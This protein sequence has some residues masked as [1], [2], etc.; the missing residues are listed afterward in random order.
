MQ[1]RSKGFDS[2]HLHYI[3]VMKSYREWLEKAKDALL[4]EQEDHIP[5]TI[6]GKTGLRVGRLGWG[7]GAFHFPTKSISQSDVDLMANTLLDAG[8]NLLD[9]AADYPNDAEGK[10]GRAIKGKRDQF[11]ILTK[12]G[13]RA[14]LLKGKEWSAA[15][16]KQ[17]VNRSLKRLQTDYLD[18]VVLHSADLEVLKKGEAFGAL[19]K[20]KDEGKIRFLGYSGDNEE[21]D[22]MI[23]LPDTSVIET[24]LNIVELANVPFFDE[25]KDK[26]IGLLAKRSIANASWKSRGRQHP[27]NWGYSSEYRERLKQIGITPTRMGLDS[28]EDRDWVTMCLPFTLSHPVDIALVGITVPEHVEEDIEIAKLKPDVSIIRKIKDMWHE[29][30]KNLANYE[31][32]QR[33]EGQM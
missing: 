27:F 26:E 4:C 24:S 12:C 5:Q 6:L 20:A 31:A 32:G 15:L 9:T 28:D 8:A 16:V 25:I 7:T 29:A 23:K 18:I 17:S 22:F 14:G 19:L 13:H 33:W 30:H 1:I 3:P 2:L 10:L 21:V 11:V